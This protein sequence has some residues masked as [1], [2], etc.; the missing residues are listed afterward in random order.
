MEIGKGVSGGAG[1]GGESGA[2]P[3]GASEAPPGGQA[4]APPGG[5]AGPPEMAGGPSPIMFRLEPGSGVPT[6]RQ[7]VQQVEQALRLGYL[8]PG[9]Q[10]PRVKD[11]VESLAINPNTV[12]KAYRELE[13]RGLAGG[14]PGQGTFVQG[15]LG[16]VGLAEQAELHRGML[17][18]L[19]AA[20]EAGLDPDGMTALFAAALREVTDGAGGETTARAGQPRRPSG[21]PGRPDAAGRGSQEGAA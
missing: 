8:E 10:L 14:R 4:G 20:V 2:A 6:Y 11:V 9:D 3:R 19:R 18:W 1:A 15:T 12:L 17:G 21:R 16:R 5:T 7:L 13:N